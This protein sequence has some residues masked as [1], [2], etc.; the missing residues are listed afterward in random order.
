MREIS[1]KTNKPIRVP[2][3]GG[4]TLFLGPGKDAQISDQAAETAAI[5]RLVEEGSIDLMGEGERADGN[6]GIAST[7]ETTQG[8]AKSPFRRRTGD[9]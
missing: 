4:K 9:R 8:R 3:P 5:L 7:A 6:T 1:N 2:L